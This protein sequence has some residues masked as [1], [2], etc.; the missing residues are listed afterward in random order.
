MKNTIISEF[1]KVKALQTTTDEQLL[2]KADVFITNFLQK[3]DGFME[4]QLEKN[5]EGNE[6]CFIIYYES[7]EKVRVV[8][9]KIRNSKEF[10]DFRALLV[11]GSISVG[12][13]LQ[14][15]KWK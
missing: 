4:A 14:I 12:F 11:P 13:N 9:E 3:Q 2:S 10:D 15:K 1:V 5:M 6:W 8:V 7:M